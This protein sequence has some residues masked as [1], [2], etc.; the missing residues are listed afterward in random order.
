[1]DEL[2]DVDYYD[3]PELSQSMLKELKKSPYHLWHKYINPDRVKETTP[4]MEFG[5]AVH[6]AILEPNLYLSNYI[7]EPK[8]DKRTKDGKL[9][10]QD[11]LNNNIGKIIISQDDY[12]LIEKIKTRLNA[13]TTWLDIV[14]CDYVVEQEIYFTLNDIKCK[15]KSDLF[16]LPC[17]KHPNG[18]IVDVKTTKDA[19][20][21]E[22]NKSIF[23][24]GYHN[25]V[26]YYQEGIMR[27]YGLLT[28]PPFLFIAIEKTEPIDITFLLADDRMGKFG[29]QENDVLMSIYKY[30][31]DNN[32]WH[33]YEDKITTVS[34]PAWVKF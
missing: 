3:R 24:L 18:L 25:Q 20:D 19:R 23:N 6:S 30:C 5:K 12:D 28:P 2:I 13:K 27:K 14:N 15:M 31:I 9:Q 33:G 7:L 8:I 11:F 1:M 4:A 34:L 26:A 21:K 22:F 32:I 17:E 10:Y 16:V 29:K